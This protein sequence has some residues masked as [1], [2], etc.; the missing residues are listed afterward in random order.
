MATHLFLLEC[1]FPRSPFSLRSEQA[2]SLSSLSKEAQEKI[3]EDVRL[4][5]EMEIFKR[6]G[7]S[8]MNYGNFKNPFWNIAGV[9]CNFIRELTTYEEKKQILTSAGYCLWD[10]CMSIT[11]K[12]GSSLDND[13]KSSEPND[14]VG[15]RRQAARR[16][17]R[18]AERLEFVGRFGSLCALAQSHLHSARRRP[19][20]HVFYHQEDCFSKVRGRAKGNKSA[21]R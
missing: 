3:L 5:V 17:N 16:A 14:I 7:E 20:Q 18:I 12:E 8:Q 19:P 6:G 21:M 13:I 1:R 4:Y 9:A 2:N 10:V 15:E 11:K